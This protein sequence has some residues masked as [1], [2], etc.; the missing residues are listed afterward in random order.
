[1]AARHRVALVTGA[2]GAI[3]RAIAAGL[4]ARPDHEVVVVGRDPQRLQRLVAELERGGAA[5]RV[6]G[7]LVDLSS[8]E[9]VR[10]LGRRF[11][12]PLDALVNAAATAPRQRTV[13][14][15]GIEVVL[16]TNVLGYVWTLEELLPALRRG[17]EP[18]VV[19]VASYWAG[20][21]DLDD[22]E[23]VRR[24]YDNDRAYRQSKQA[25]RMLTRAVAE[26][27]A[28]DGITVHA[29]H[30]GDVAS[31][32]SLD[33]GFGGAESPEAGARTPLWLAT[34]AEVPG[35]TGGYYEH[36]RRAECRFS[37]DAAA[38]AA[39]ARRVAAYP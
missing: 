32:L 24:R 6:R 15:A 3:G 21:L 38:V 35:E 23:F 39:L 11:T 30:P 13:T 16:A 26:R 27:L 19:N 34:R 5:G 2:Y 31:K 8:H 20:D 29:C 7:E 9:D 37:R 18:R 17:R 36:E 28:P 10:A 22:L 14:A 4:V 25:N 12:G 1:M 33:L